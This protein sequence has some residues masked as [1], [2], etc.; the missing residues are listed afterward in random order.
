MMKGFVVGCFL[1]LNGVIGLQSLVDVKVDE[2]PELSSVTTSNKVSSVLRDILNQE[3]L[4]RFSMVQKIQGLAMDAI[5]NKNNSQAMKRKIGD[6]MSEL[7]ASAENDRKIE[8]EN[9]KFK[10]EL[11]TINETNQNLKEDNVKLNEQIAVLNRTLKNTVTEEQFDVFKKDFNLRL[12]MID[13]NLQNFT[14]SINKTVENLITEQRNASTD[15]SR[16]GIYCDCE[17][18]LEKNPK[19][20]EID[21]VYDIVPDNITSVRVYCDMTTDRG[22]WTVIQRRF[23]GKTDFHRKWN[24]YKKGFGNPDREYWLGNDKIHALTNK[25]NQELHIDMEKFTGSMVY[26]RYSHFSVGSESSEYRLSISDYSGNAGDMMI[27]AYTLNGMSFTTK[28]RDNDGNRGYNCA[29]KYHTGG[30]WYNSC[31]HSDLNGVY[32]PSNNRNERG[33]F[34]GINDENMKTTKMMV[35]SKR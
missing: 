3:S 21:G 29:V 20:F 2:K 11:R 17:E 27:Q 7:Q 23:D 9:S 1:I 33:L 6:M 10:E 28:D 32:Q 26:A 30:W 35:R 25:R 14:L 22:G 19:F 34:W 5:D 15:P 8:V 31:A 18:I 4:V 12:Q 16:V 24:D 13:T